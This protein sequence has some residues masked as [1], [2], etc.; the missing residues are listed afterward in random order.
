MN[1][2]VLSPWF[3]YP[4]DNGSRLRAYHLLRNLN[5][6]GHRIR[7]VAGRQTDRQGEDGPTDDDLRVHLG[8]ESVVSAAWHW[9]QKGQGGPTGALRALL[10]PTPRSIL[11]TDNP[12]LR[13]AMN[14][15]YAQPTDAVLAL[16]L[17]SAPFVPPVNGKQG[18]SPPVVLDQIEMSGPVQARHDAVNV[19]ARLR[20]GLTVWKSDR[21]WRRAVRRFAAL[22]TVSDDEACVVRGVIGEPHSGAPPVVVVPNGVDVSSY[23][24][25]ASG[26]A[27]VPGRLV[28][29]GA[30]GYGPNREAVLWF[31]REM[32]PRIA[33]QV[34]QAHLVVTG[35]TD[36]V[37]A[38]TRSVLDADER[39]RLT[40]FLPDLRPA[41]DAA[42]VC[43]V[44]LRAGGGTR[45]K[46]LEAFAAGLPVVATARGA[47]GIQA[48]HGRHLLLA[49]T[50][51]E[52]VSGV[53]RLLQRPDEAASLAREARRLV[54]EHYDWPAIASG[55]SDLLERVAAR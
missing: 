30:L 52:I 6:Q 51:D 8:C 37:D 29:N 43:V 21:Y 15:G 32:L 12:A 25:G 36:D 45:L 3:P 13:K 5:A 2:F 19:R 42:Q 20:A 23:Q 49:D 40:G 17:G 34:P 16:E 55:L 39:V 4:A 41:L 33:D 9:H 53:A 14:A 1:L 11:E 7:L 38:Q 44:P 50:P 47:A 31:V 27:P 22:T 24:R 54:E 18:V 26:V 48:E 10:S 35:R 28:Y 46:I